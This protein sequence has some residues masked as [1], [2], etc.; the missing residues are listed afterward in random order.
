MA[1]LKD[2]VQGTKFMLA[3]SISGKVVS[4]KP[5][6]YVATSDALRARAKGYV[7]ILTEQGQISGHKDNA[8]VIVK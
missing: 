1:T 3:D 2:I 7:V 5:V 6:L 4:P 8:I